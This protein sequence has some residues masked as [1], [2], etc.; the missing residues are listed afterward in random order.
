MVESM[1]NFTQ[2]LSTNSNDIPAVF[3][4]LAPQMSA[5]T[6]N[7]TSRVYAVLR[8]T[9]LE[10]GLASGTQLPPSRTLAEWLGVPR[11]AV[12][13]AYESLQGD[14][15]LV[16]RVG[17]GSFVAHGLHKVQP[18]KSL[19]NLPLNIPPKGPIKAFALGV[20]MADAVFQKRLASA[21]RQH[22][23]HDDLTRLAEGDPRGSIQLREMIAH[24]LRQSRGVMCLPEQI[25][26]TMGT[27]QVLRVCAQA[28]MQA[29]DPVWME[30]PGYPTAWRTLSAAGLKPR[31]TPVDDEG[32]AA[33]ATPK[34]LGPAKAIYVTPS[35]QFPTGAVMSLSRRMALLEWA[36][37]HGAW[38]FEDDYDSECRYRGP[39]LTA[40]AGLDRSERVIYMGSFSKSAYPALRL[41]YAVVP[42]SALESVVAARSTFDRFAPP[43][44]E[45]ALADLMADGSVSQHLR[46][47]RLNDKRSRDQL[48]ERLQQ[49]SQGV[50]TVLSPDQGSHLLA[51][52]PQGVSSEIAQR[53]RS[54]TGLSLILLSELRQVHRKT[55][56]E[57]FVVGFAGFSQK[58]IDQGATLLGEAAFK[59]VT[60]CLK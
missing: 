49:S 1:S 17:A 51:W 35:H 23:L 19:E 43:M 33:L 52:L 41:A 10:G 21:V 4:Q 11:H 27:Q 34:G 20:P 8:N 6:G 26:I 5:Y 40:L 32:I 54:T 2:F 58:E 24:E 56:R 36:H 57:A 13:G 47:A 31:P 45:L 15:L 9:I 50:L 42:H 30:D 12:V 55:D 28:L 46:R 60:R 25:M 7:Q 44:L 39:P 22:L 59:H 16:A 14:G 48:V 29:G 18:Q 38:I 53:I 37:R 3:L